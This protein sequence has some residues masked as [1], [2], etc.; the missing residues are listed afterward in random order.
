MMAALLALG[1]A[2]LASGS[3]QPHDG[4]ETV[5][6][7]FAWRWRRGEPDA[8]TAAS[9]PS[10]T[11]TPDALCPGLMQR[12]CA[13]NEF[14]SR[15]DPSTGSCN[16]TSTAVECELDCC[17]DPACGQWAWKATDDGSN[18]CW[19]S[20]GKNTTGC[21]ASAGWV[22]G[23]RPTPGPRM[24]P[25]S[26]VPAS[27]AYDDSAWKGVDV[28]HDARLT[29]RFDRKYHSL[30]SLI[31]LF[32]DSPDRFFAKCSDSRHVPWP[33]EAALL[34]LMVPEAISRSGKLG[35]QA[36]VHYV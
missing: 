23:T 5:S 19:W 17:A 27:M 12:R 15:T 28:P 18:R 36:S 3:S 1:L 16:D 10:L 6:F 31:K 20:A 30:F 24:G 29:E 11:P 13:Q 7:N 26:L 8:A 22:G 2:A 14:S 9:C 32:V 34:Q 21:A 25:R 33:G 4:R 35:R